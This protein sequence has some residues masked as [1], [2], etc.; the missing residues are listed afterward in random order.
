MNTQILR[1]TSAIERLETLQKELLVL[2]DRVQEHVDG[3][4][5]LMQA[6]SEIVR[7]MAEAVSE[8]LNRENEN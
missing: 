3:L 5:Y 8:V 4:S 6:Q 7:Q 1:P 2:E